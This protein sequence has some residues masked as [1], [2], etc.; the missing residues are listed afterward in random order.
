MIELAIL[1]IIIVA[2]FKFNSTVN[3]YSRGAED[4][5]SNWLEDKL[6][7]NADERQDRIKEIKTLKEQHGIDKLATSEDVLKE[8][9][10]K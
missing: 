5:T 7:E 1:I 10:F 3:L 8:L 6:L 9:G 2:L 4:T